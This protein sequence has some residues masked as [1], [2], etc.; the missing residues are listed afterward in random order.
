LRQFI[1]SDRCSLYKV[2]RLGDPNEMNEFFGSGLDEE[3][4]E[5][6]SSSPEVL[7]PSSAQRRLRQRSGT[8][9]VPTVQDK[10]ADNCDDSPAD[11]IQRDHTDQQEREH[12]EG[13]ATL[14]GAVSPC[15]HNFRNA[16]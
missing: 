2:W 7:S 4:Q 5:Q 15:D 13:G 9:P 8:R 10:T 11:G 16:D 12:H 14:T 1:G 6:R 3:S